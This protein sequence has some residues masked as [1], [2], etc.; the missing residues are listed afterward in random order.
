[1]SSL[2]FCSTALSSCCCLCRRFSAHSWRRSA[3][4]FSAARFASAARAA[5]RVFSGVAV[6]SR[7]AGCAGGAAA[8][9]SETGGWTAA[10]S[11][12]TAG[13]ARVDPEL[14]ASVC[15][16]A[17][18]C[19]GAASSPFRDQRPRVA[20]QATARIASRRVLSISMP[21][22]NH[23]RF[24]FAIRGCLRRDHELG[25]IARSAPANATEAVRQWIF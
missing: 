1:M 7:A 24:R 5:A 9:V 12:A 16:S 15:A 18:G 19:T 25:S 3:L 11:C 20:A 6:C 17:G 10:A 23:R 21:N 4:R 13:C 8:C 2:T 22:G 14:P